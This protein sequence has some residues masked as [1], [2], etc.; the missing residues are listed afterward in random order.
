MSGKKYD[1][2]FLDNEIN[3]PTPSKTEYDFSFLDDEPSPP[4]EERGILGNMIDAP[5]GQAAGVAGSLANLSE[6]T[7]GVGEDVSSYMREVAAENQRTKD[8][9][10]EDKI[11]FNSDY[12]TNPSGAL[13]DV[14]GTAGSAVALGGAQLALEK[15]VAS[16]LLTKGVD[17]KQLP[18]VLPAVVA[19][20]M[21]GLNTAN[22]SGLHKAINALTAVTG[23]E[24]LSSAGTTAGEVYEETGSRT[25]ATDAGIKTALA[26]APF[27][28][29]LNKLQTKLA[30][31]TLEK[32]GLGKVWTAVKDSLISGVEEGMQN[33]T[34]KFGK[35]EIDLVDVY[36][37]AEWDTEAWN[38]AAVGLISG[39]GRQ[40]VVNAADVAIKKLKA[41]DAS[42]EKVEIPEEDEEPQNTSESESVGEN[43]YE[44]AD[45]IQTARDEIQDWRETISTDDVQEY[46][47]LTKILED[48]T[49]EEIIAEAEAIRNGSR[50][51]EEPIEV[52][53]DEEDSEDNEE[54]VA[55]E[56]EAEEVEAEVV[57]ETAPAPSTQPL[58]IGEPE[59]VK[60]TIE[61]S[62]VDPLTSELPAEEPIVEATITP[63]GD[64]AEEEEVTKDLDLEKSAQ[65][66]DDIWDR[67]G[68][69]DSK[70]KNQIEREALSKNFTIADLVKD[71][72]ARLENNYNDPSWREEERDTKEFKDEK[73][74][75]EDFVKKWKKQEVSTFES[76]E[77]FKDKADFDKWLGPTLASISSTDATQKFNNIKQK[78]FD[79]LDKV[80]KN[81][82]LDADKLKKYK[83][84]IDDYIELIKYNL[85]SNGDFNVNT[86]PDE[87]AGMKLRGD[88]GQTY[89]VVYM[90][91][92]DEWTADVNVPR[93]VIRAQN[94]NGRQTGKFTVQRMVNN[95]RGLATDFYKTDVESF[96]D[97]YSLAEEVEAQKRSEVIAR[98]LIDGLKKNGLKVYTSADSI[99][100]RRKETN[101]EQEAWIDDLGRVVVKQADGKTGFVR[102]IAD[103]NSNTIWVNLSDPDAIQTPIHE[104]THIWNKI[105]KKNYPELWA[106]GVEL[107]KQS[108]IWQEVANDP[109]YANLKSED[110]IA[111]EVIAR[112]AGVKSEEI[113]R[114]I[115]K[116][117]E[118]LASG[119]KGWVQKYWKGV[120]RFF[121]RSVNKDI[122]NLTL[123]EFIQMAI[124]DAVGETKL[125]DLAKKKPSTGDAEVKKKPPQDDKP[126]KEEPPKK[127]NAAEFKDK[128]GDFEV[129][130]F[131]EMMNHKPNARMYAKVDPSDDNEF[132]YA[133]LVA[134]D[135]GFSVE[136]EYNAG[137][138]K[139]NKSFKTLEEAED[140]ISSF[141]E[142]E[143]TPNEEV[144]DEEPNVKQRPPR[145]PRKRNSTEPIK[146]DTPEEVYNS[147]LSRL[148]KRPQKVIQDAKE[149]II[150][151]LKGKVKLAVNTKAKDTFYA[152][153]EGIDSPVKISKTI[154]TGLKVMANIDDADVRQY[155]PEVTVKK[156][157]W[158]PWQSHDAIMESDDLES[159]AIRWSLSPVNGLEILKGKAKEVVDLFTTEVNG[160]TLDYLITKAAAEDMLSGTED[161]F[162]D[163]NFKYISKQLSEVSDPKLLPRLGD[164]AQS[165]YEFLVT[166]YGIKTK[167]DKTKEEEIKKP[168][169]SPTVKEDEKP[170]KQ[171]EEILGKLGEKFYAKDVASIKEFAEATG[172]SFKLQKNGVLFEEIKAAYMLAKKVKEFKPEASFSEIGNFFELVRKKRRALEDAKENARKEKTY[173]VA[174]A[175]IQEFRKKVG[176]AKT[177]D[178]Q[179]KIAQEFNDY[180]QSE[181]YKGYLDTVQKIAGFTELQKELELDAF[182]PKM[183]NDDGEKLN[184]VWDL[185]FNKTSDELMIDSAD[186]DVSDR[187]KAIVLAIRY[188]NGESAKDL[189]VETGWHRNDDGSWTNGIDF[190]NMKRAEP[191]DVDEELAKRG[192]RAFKRGKKLTASEEIERKGFKQW[193]K[194]W[195]T[196][197]KKAFVREGFDKY[198]IIK[199][200]DAAVEEATGEKLDPADTIY[201][202]VSSVLSRAQGITDALIKGSK[203][204]IKVLNSK[205]KRVKLK[206]DVTLFDVLQSVNDEKMKDVAPDY[207]EEYGF[208]S[209]IE[210][211]GA[212][213]GWRRL[214][215]MTVLRLE[216]YEEAL[217]KWE[218]LND[219]MERWREGGKVGPSPLAAAHAEWVNFM[220]QVNK[221][222]RAWKKAGSIGVDPSEGM[223]V[224]WLETHD[225]LEEPPLR[226]GKR[227]EYEPYVSPEGLTELDLRRLI[228]N[229]PKEFVEGAEL[230]YKLNDNI[231]CILEDAGIIDAETHELLN[232]KYRNYAPLMRDFSDTAAAEEYFDGLTSKG[233]SGVANVSNVL[234]S[235]SEEGSG[236][237]V[238]NPLISTVNAITV[239]VNRAERNKAGQHLVRTMTSSDSLS[240]F[241]ERLPNPAHGQPKADPL[242][243]VFT[244]MYN[245]KKVAYRCAP[246]F[247]EAIVGYKAPTG[248][249]IFNAAKITAKV[250]RGG[251]TMSPSF[252]LRNLMKDTVG[253]GVASQNGFVPILDTIRGARALMKDPKFRA[254]FESSGVISFSD[255]G[256]PESAYS[257]LVALNGGKQLTIYEPKAIIEGILQAVMKRKGLEALKDIGMG[258]GQLSAFL[259]SATRAGEFKRA[260]ESGKSLE[261][262]AM[263]ARE[264][265]VNFS[266]SGVAGQKI[267]QTIPFF[268]ATIQGGYLFYRLMQKHPKRTVARLVEYILLPSLAL[269]IFTHDED[270]YKELDPKIKYTHWCLPNGVRIPKPQEYGVLV[271]GGVEALLDQAWSKDSRAIAEWSKALG[272]MIGP[273]VLPTLIKPLIEWN[274]NYS[275]FKGGELVPKRL[276]NMPPELQYTSG[277]TEASKFIG[278]YTGYSPIKI[279]NTVRGYLGT[280]GMILYQTPDWF[281]AEKQNLPA[282]KLSEMQII[283]DFS[284]NKNHLNRYVNDFYDLQKIANEQHNAYGKKGRPDRSVK[285]IRKAGQTIS[286]LNKDIR[287]ITES[288]KYT[289]ERKRELIEGK[290][291]KIKAIA[292]KTVDKYGEEYL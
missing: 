201:E 3:E 38:D 24:L 274:T 75:L 248:N 214:R 138:A 66:F 141:N 235:I 103:S 190:E 287:K 123:D 198:D 77:T 117:N 121:E 53:V 46:E 71:V 275:F 153:F 189:Q 152:Y 172:D 17:V 98:K 244:I 249:I 215:E 266:R 284:V 69:E 4:K 217:A 237:T 139:V 282:K 36:N 233:G 159:C 226:V 85:A 212:Y 113:F 174:A 107:A 227:P 78:L 25:K 6:V 160:K 220:K 168:V 192:R 259:E 54:P 108:T 114:Q 130:Q 208:K 157:G 112:L 213:L 129:D 9:S 126:P 246:E 161:A 204:H 177:Q 111:D 267:N 253:A 40:A 225:S 19:K 263:D 143:E 241:I 178:E 193:F 99:L 12:Y 200:L 158:T 21:A 23:A 144:K 272:S 47:R 232:T 97:A 79:V 224:E 136:M 240:P 165:Y 154:Y 236:R 65:E 176:A 72:E 279:D 64:E 11:P 145:K 14:A 182:V 39:A 181:G 210:A 270:W 257:N 150:N 135:D 278:K 83:D 276:Q 234:K 186:D 26:E 148:S 254:E 76:P 231:L 146:A 22:K 205:M 127:K 50:A 84:G 48:G 124:I 132:I 228:D 49:D 73:K 166:K 93:W 86:A 289:P 133:T 80:K 125:K 92:K 52:D 7:L 56:V 247:Y 81:G 252:I 243:S 199:V 60:E 106:K 170:S 285:A 238:I 194:D 58:M 202:K 283:R 33:R 156:V 67:F 286:E 162:N 258:L 20:W 142:K 91:D 281:A 45:P 35:D 87:I 43:E 251:V 96:E 88:G 37:L 28:I 218:A 15:A 55:E 223:K 29:I 271:G 290:E 63:D 211:F 10:L 164:I 18:T 102:G 195:V 196:D 188:E 128:L 90:F 242:N 250:L 264:V 173:K 68:D 57:Q 16:Y 5:I 203:Y 70:I 197:R 221:A 115:A 269:W 59:P 82:I 277:T 191:A 280:M 118:E 230:Y 167:G 41:D 151:A 207:L 131:F 180:K 169:E 30:F 61:T 239:A 291:A 116:Q 1:F 8:Y 42:K 209:W 179:E 122:A 288:N 109:R 229:A 101:P 245:G 171:D 219:A 95:G 13:Y 134:D 120:K 262:A 74:A 62:T 34:Q 2:S 185:A 140:Y 137:K 268:N 183:L 261:E 155:N 184:K 51:K 187:K 89:S 27:E 149:F 94:D 260:R 163:I 147:Y 292:K 105:I 110:Q 31:E 100:K 273:D 104:Y 206:H 256:D 175:K 255:Y 222:H 216:K 119:L 32:S 265:T 44:E